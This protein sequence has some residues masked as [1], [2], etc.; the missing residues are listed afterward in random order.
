MDVTLQ[1]DKPIDKMSRWSE[2]SQTRLDNFEY[3]L[4][5][6]SLK[7]VSEVPT[8]NFARNRNAQSFIKSIFETQNYKLEQLIPFSHHV[9]RTG[10][11][12]RMQKMN[13][14]Y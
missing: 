10:A 12:V 5:Q 6:C 11:S 8:V 13:E 4:V 9:R 2:V 3:S 14:Q 7:N 1:V